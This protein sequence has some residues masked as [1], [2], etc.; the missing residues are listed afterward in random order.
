MCR[1]F[2]VISSDLFNEFGNINSCGTPFNTWSII[3]EK[4]AVSLY[5]SSFFI[6]KRRRDIAE[7][8]RVFGLGKSVFFNRHAFIFLVCLVCM[9]LNKNIFKDIAILLWR[10]VGMRLLELHEFPISLRSSISEKLPCISYFLDHIKI[11]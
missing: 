5:K 2:D 8:F 4:T 10:R 3:K 1:T 6:F 11:K 9:S 7:V